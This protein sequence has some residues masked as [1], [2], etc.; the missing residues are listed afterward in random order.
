[1]SYIP[2]STAADT[3]IGLRSWLLQELNRIANGFTIAEQTTSLP[4]LTEEP[5]K[6]A[7]GQLVF[8]DGTS[9]NPGSGRGLYYYDTNGWTFIA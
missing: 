1:M 8:A 7:T 6:R 5:A 2:S 9:W 4:V 3:A